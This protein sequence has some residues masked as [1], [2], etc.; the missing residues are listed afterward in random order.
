MNAITARGL[1]GATAKGGRTRELSP[2]DDLHTLV[3]A[4]AR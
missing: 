4:D 1:R 3:I 2:E